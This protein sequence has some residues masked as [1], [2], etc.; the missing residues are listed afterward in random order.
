M[1]DFFDVQF[2]TKNMTFEELQ[3]ARD[4]ALDV[5]LSLDNQILLREKS[6]LKHQYSSE[7]TGVL[8]IQNFF[9]VEVDTRNMTLEELQEARGKTLD[10]LI[11]LDSPISLPKKE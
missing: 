10:L 4:K 7:L 11:Y 1:Q 6:R 8:T 5:L 2:D 3:E 9:N